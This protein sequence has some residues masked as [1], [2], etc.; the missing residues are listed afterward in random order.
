[1]I[2][3]IFFRNIAGSYNTSVR[4]ICGGHVETMKLP[5]AFAE[6]PS[7]KVTNAQRS[8]SAFAKSLNDQRGPMIVLLILNLR[9]DDG[10]GANKCG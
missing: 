3:K 1:M 2:T 9:H 6:S 4:Q 8:R 10:S 5:K 7:P